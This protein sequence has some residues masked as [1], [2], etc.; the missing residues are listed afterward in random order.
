MWLLS[1]QNHLT[2]LI[3]IGLLLWAADRFSPS[4]RPL[5]SMGLRSVVLIGLAQALALVPGTS[6]S[7]ITITAG[8]A[9]GFTPD[10]AARFSFLLSAPVILLATVYKGG[11]LVLSAAPVPWGELALGVVVSAVV[12][13]GR[14]RRRPRA[15]V[16]AS[17]VGRVVGSRPTP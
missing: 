16:P 13:S 9:L 6:R 5:E 3:L 17:G 1:K 10:A 2:S 14:R 4:V 8:P 11:E 15:A 7:G 12:S